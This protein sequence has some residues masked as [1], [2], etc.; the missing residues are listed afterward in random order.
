MFKKI[1]K[2]VLRHKG[3][4]LAYTKEMKKQDELWQTSKEDL[5]MMYLLQSRILDEAKQK[6]WQGYAVT[7]EVNNEEV[8]TDVY[9]N[10]EDY[11]NQTENFESFGNCKGLI[12]CLED[13]MNLKKTI[14]N[15]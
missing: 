9:L 8:V 13:I 6:G 5:K 12:K 14:L 1:M 11:D 3:I 2:L 15:Y 10:K 4:K 7:Y